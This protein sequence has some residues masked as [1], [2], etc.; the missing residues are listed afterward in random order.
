MI[1][2]AT[3]DD[4][5]EITAIY[6]H[7]VLHGVA[8]FDTQARTEAEIGDWFFGA[9]NR[10]PSLTARQ[11]GRV[12]G[13]ARLYRWSPRQGYDDT[14]ENAVYVHPDFRGLGLGKALLGRILERGRQNRFR[15]VIARIA[16]ENQLSR[17]LHEQAGFRHVGVLREAG[18]KFGRLLDV[19][20]FQRMLIPG[21]LD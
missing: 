16:A 3:L 12:A 4:L 15:T 7:E 18:L 21:A 5:P 8:T 13:F 14:V 1:S 9:G 10:Y 6:N 20:L 2:P 17:R 11:D 19:D